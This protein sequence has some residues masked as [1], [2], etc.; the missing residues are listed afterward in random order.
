LKYDRWNE[1]KEDIVRVTRT[2]NAIYEFQAKNNG[3]GQFI[4]INERMA[5][6]AYRRIRM[7]QDIDWTWVSE[8]CNVQ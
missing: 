4:P 7:L 8:F 5:L 6:F 1:R 3:N 2:G